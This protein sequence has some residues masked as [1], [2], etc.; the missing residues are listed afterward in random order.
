MQLTGRRGALVLAAVLAAAAV[1]APAQGRVLLHRCVETGGSWADTAIQ[2]AVLRTA[3]ACPDGALGLGAAP[4]GAVLLLS[5]AL[6]VLALHVL[7]AALG[8]GLGAIVARAARVV[9]GLVVRRVPP[10]RVRALPVARRV[11]VP[12]GNPDLPRPTLGLLLAR[13]H[14]APPLPA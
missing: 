2:L 9:A 5:V 1:A 6:P 3:S 4:R 11:L 14:R 7:L 12:V 8:I 13:P 10:P